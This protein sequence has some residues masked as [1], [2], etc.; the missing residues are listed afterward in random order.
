MAHIVLLGDSVF[1][2]APY[3]AAG[4]EVIQQ[5]RRRLPFDWQATLLARDGTVLADLT[6]Q[7]RHV[8]T[9]ATHLIVSA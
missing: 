6:E 3:V 8:P 7:I 5:L 9:G 2:N 1:D 4:Q